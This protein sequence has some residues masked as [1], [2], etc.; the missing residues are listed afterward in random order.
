MSGYGSG[1]KIREENLVSYFDLL[2]GDTRSITKVLP[3]N[4]CYAAVWAFSSRP[5]RR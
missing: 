4:T 3:F 1:D 2:D 5:T